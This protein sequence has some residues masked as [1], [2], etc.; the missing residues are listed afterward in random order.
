LLTILNNANDA[1]KALS[2]EITGLTVSELAERLGTSASTASRLLAAMC[3]AGMVEKL[4]HSQKHVVSLNMWPVG[5]AARR[6]QRLADMALG[7]M[8]QFADRHGVGVALGVR[9][10]DDIIFIQDVARVRGTIVATAVAA[11]FPLRLNAAGRA[12]LA[13]EKA[14][15]APKPVASATSQSPRSPVGMEQQRDDLE[16]VRNMGYAVNTGELGDGRCGLAAPVFDL[17]N[18]AVAAVTAACTPSE[19]SEGFEAKIGPDLRE[20]GRTISRFLGYEDRLGIC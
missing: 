10:D 11:R 16:D 19:W 4:P 20:L 1:L 7:P 18:Q 5:A 12:M 3:A 14:G 2:S 15:S 13:F 9:K 8:V 6:H 17:S